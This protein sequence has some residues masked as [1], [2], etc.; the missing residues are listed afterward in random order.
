MNNELSVD[1]GDNSDDWIG[2]F[3]QNFSPETLQEFDFRTAN[4]DADT[5]GTTAGSVVIITKS[6]TNVWHGSGSFYGRASGLNARFPIENPAPEPK[7][8]FSRENYIGTIGGPIAEN[9]VW[10][11]VSFEHVHENAS[12]NYSSDNTAEFNALAQ[13]AT[14][15]LITGVPSIAVPSSVPVPFRDYLASLRFDWAQSPKSQWFVRSSADSYI[16]HNAPEF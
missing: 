9:K 11:F 13:L 1:G 5:G 10:M 2:G 7:Q 14:D 15:G 4:Q 8:P 12:I 6:G 16:T 3:L